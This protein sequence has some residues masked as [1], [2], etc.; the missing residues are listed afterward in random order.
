ML[1]VISF[2]FQMTPTQTREDGDITEC[3]WAPKREKPITCWG[4]ANSPFAPAQ[5]SHMA[6]KQ[7]NKRTNEEIHSFFLF[8]IVWFKLCK[9]QNIAPRCFKKSHMASKQTN[10]RMNEEIHS[11]LFTIIWFKLYRYTIIVRSPLNFNLAIFVY[12]GKIFYFDGSDG[13][14]L[15]FFFT[16]SCRE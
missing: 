14:N 4:C 16:S 15:F 10:K 8:T 12:H 11:F 9:F 13:S 2:L 5:K 1:I 7:T 6:S 3:P